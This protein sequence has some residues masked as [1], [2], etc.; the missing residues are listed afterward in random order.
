MIPPM[1]GPQAQAIM[2]A[3]PNLLSMGVTPSS[4][5]IATPSGMSIAAT[6]VLVIHIDSSM[7]TARKP[8]TIMPVELP[9]RLRR[10]TEMRFPRPLRVMKLESTSTPIKKTKMWLPNPRFTIVPKSSTR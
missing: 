4:R 9:V 7:P 2:S 10:N 3:L 6:A 1:I 5:R 8:K